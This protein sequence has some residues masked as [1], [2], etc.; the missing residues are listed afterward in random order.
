MKGGGCSFFFFCVVF[1]C[2]EYSWD[3]YSFAFLQGRRRRDV[4]HFKNRIIFQVV[5]EI[6]SEKNVKDKKE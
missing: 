5:Q 1:F 2:H 6:E 4:S 3:I